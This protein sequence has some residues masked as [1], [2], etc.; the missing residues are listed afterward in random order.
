MGRGTGAAIASGLQTS[1]KEMGIADEIKAVGADSTATNTGC[2]NGAI[3]GLE[4]LL[5]LLLQWIICSLHLNELPLRH[6]CKKY[7][8]TKESRTQWK[9]HIGKDL[10]SCKSLPV[11]SMSV[12]SI[13]KG[14]PLPDI[15]V[16]ELSRDQ[17][18]LYKNQSINQSI[19][20][21]PYGFNELTPEG[22]FPVT[23]LSTP[24]NHHI[25]LLSAL[26]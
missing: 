22:F 20:R 7:I 12:K 18:F 3:Q 6:L 21:H 14:P 25:Q 23:S 11:S 19:L 4:Q 2:K 24:V 26:S 8:G 16:N 5:N 15:D 13:G 1:I 17:A 9:G 10:A